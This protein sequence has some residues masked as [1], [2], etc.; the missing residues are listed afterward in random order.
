MEINDL[1][2]QPDAGLSDSS[3]CGSLP[4]EPLV[5]LEGIAR[6]VYDPSLTWQENEGIP[7]PVPDPIPDTPVN[8]DDEGADRLLRVAKRRS[9]KGSRPTS[10]APR[11]ANKVQ[12]KR[13]AKEAGA[14]P[15]RTRLVFSSDM[16]ARMMELFSA[17]VRA[18]NFKNTKT[19]YPKRVMERV[20]KT[21]ESEYPRHP[22]TIPKLEYKLRKE[23][24]RYGLFLA[25]S[26]MSGVKYD[27][28]SGLP[29]A[30]EEVWAKFFA[31]YP[32][33]RWLRTQPLGDRTAYADVYHRYTATGQ[34]IRPASAL[35]GRFSDSDDDMDSDDIDSD[36]SGDS[37]FATW[38][39]SAAATV[40]A[41][42]RLAAS[43]SS[44]VL[45]GTADVEA[46][47]KGVQR[48]FANKM[49]P[50]EM[51]KVIE[52]FVD[53]ECAITWNRLSTEGRAELAKE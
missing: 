46:A 40:R 16:T 43:S 52:H 4:D 42:E 1:L 47:S 14:V 3:D 38:A 21:M 25:L 15:A 41:I 34:Y 29:Q 33:G 26:A 50:A 7:D 13:R 20:R 30:P 18:G 10:R 51:A 39:R 23:E 53:P 45:P 8:S 49:T 35:V 19:D 36:E 31:K 27:Q 2:T 28:P 12:K 11:S 9:T 32:E 6:D 22:W 44:D 17:E 5:N 24:N 48:E 37:E